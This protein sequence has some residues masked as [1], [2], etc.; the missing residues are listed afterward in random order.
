VR[1]WCVLDCAAA[2]FVSPVVVVPPVAEGEPA[3]SRACSAGVS[4]SM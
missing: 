2:F 3:A 4:C 1:E